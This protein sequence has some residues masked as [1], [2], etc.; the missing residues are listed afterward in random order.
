MNTLTIGE[1]RLQVSKGKTLCALC[2]EHR[3]S[4]VHHLN[5]N[6]SDDRPENLAPA[7]KLCHDEI[8]GITAQLNDLTLLVRQYYNIQ[9]MRVAMSQRLQAHHKLGY[10]VKQSGET[11]DRLL[12]LEKHVGG[13]VAKMVKDE[14]IYNAWL[15]HVKGIGPALSAAIITRIGSIDRFESISSLWAY[16]GLDVRNGRAR[17]R[18]NSKTIDWNTDL[19]A[20]IAYKVPSQ[21]VKLPSSFGRKLY[22]EYKAFYERVHD[23][24]CPTWSDP[25]AVINKI[26]TKATVGRKGCSRK[27]HIHNMTKRKVGK[28]FLACLW[29]AWRKLERLP[30]SEPYS[31]RSPNHSHVITP[32]DWIE[33]NQ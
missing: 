33:N 23:E 2:E 9:E 14:P 24:R 5:G 22:D 13:I 8:H 10:Y 26:G 28:V 11:H 18:C 7:C 16:S 19:K 32:E 12:E 1:L 15:K 21:F 31:T 25:N 4:D 6:H 20:I 27:G 3:A 30:I 17:Q 29:L